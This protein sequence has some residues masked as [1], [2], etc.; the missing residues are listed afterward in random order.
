MPKIRVAAIGDVQEGHIKQ[1]TAGELEII[2]VRVEGRVR[3]F[4]AR[5]PH[6][7]APLADGLLDG[8]RLLCPWHQSVFRVTDGELLEPPALAGLACFEV[9]IDADGRSR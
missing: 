8:D 1:V 3:A 5:C 2:L 6:H 4:S 7:D 9:D